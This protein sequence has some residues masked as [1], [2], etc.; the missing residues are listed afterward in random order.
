MR[1]DLV[2]ATRAVNLQL[3]L[4]LLFEGTGSVY[5]C[6]VGHAEV[7]GGEDKN[8]T[9]QEQ[10]GHENILAATDLQESLVYSIDRFFK[11]HWT[12][13]KSPLLKN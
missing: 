11:F 1:L 8:A 7:D 10:H 9:D 4:Q 13:T 5:E 2:S 6:T 3:L 12:K